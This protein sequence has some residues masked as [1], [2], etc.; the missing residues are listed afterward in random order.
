MDAALVPS[1]S[2]AYGGGKFGRKIA[3][4]VLAVQRG[5]VKAKLDILPTDTFDDEP[6]KPPRNQKATPAPKSKPL[7]NK[8]IKRARQAKP[9]QPHSDQLK[10]NQSD[11]VQAEPTVHAVHKVHSSVPINPRPAAPLS[12]GAVALSNLNLPA[13]ASATAGLPL[14][15]DDCPLINPIP[16]IL[17]MAPIS[18]EDS[19]AREVL[20]ETELAE[21]GHALSAYSLGARYR[22]GNGVPQDLAKARHWLGKAA[23]QGIGG[24]KIEL[25]ALV[26]R[27]GD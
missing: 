17:P 10:A 5:D 8:K 3:A 27:F 25:R 14:P 9:T 15:A 22:D 12:E 19:E 11:F 26:L 23:S 16:P 24:A 18:P 20:H 7:A 21:Q 4:Y 6:V 1:L 13:I 2:Y